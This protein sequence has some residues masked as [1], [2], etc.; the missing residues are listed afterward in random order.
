M[1]RENMYEPGSPFF[2]SPMVYL[3]SKY[4][5]NMFAY[6]LTLPW[7]LK[8]KKCLYLKWTQLPKLFLYCFPAT[9]KTILKAFNPPILQSET[10]LCFKLLLSQVSDIEICC[11]IRKIQSGTSSGDSELPSS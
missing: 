10:S 2:K 5:Q 1:K 9:V 4:L 3:H 7:F 6:K 11:N 8:I